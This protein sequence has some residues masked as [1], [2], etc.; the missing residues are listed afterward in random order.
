[1]MPLWRTI[2]RRCGRF[3]VRWLF[4]LLTHL[5]VR[6][7]E[8]IPREG[9]LIIAFNH[10]GHLDG[11]LVI[12]FVPR[13][14]EG[15]ALVDLLRVPGTGQL[16]KL[17]GV[18]PVH[19]DELDRRVIREALKVLAE[20]KALALAPEARMSVTRALEKARHGVAYLALQSGAPVLPVA[21][22]GTEKALQDLVHLRRPVLTLTFG[23]PIAPPPKA[24]DRKQRR[25]QMA[26]F[27][28]R[29][30]REIA[31]MLP[32]KYRGVYA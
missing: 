31:R 11:P 16:L 5:E 22:T 17:Y 7:Q 9:P 6:G 28:E 15:I 25:E 23:K 1:M 13:T 29:I 8:N 24:F 3:L 21:I 10:L 20:G 30:M 26:E 32:P 18:I 4:R 27:T 2:F 19:R 12:A 14:V